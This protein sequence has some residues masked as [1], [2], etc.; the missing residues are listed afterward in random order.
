MIIGRINEWMNEWFYF[1]YEI[2]VFYRDRGDYWLSM[3]RILG[4]VYRKGF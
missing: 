1:C 3:V 2:L 4:C